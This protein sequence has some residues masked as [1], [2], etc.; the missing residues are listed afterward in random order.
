[1]NKYFIASLLTLS[2][3]AS[4]Q[5]TPPTPPGP[6]TGHPA[7]P[8]ACTTSG[9][10]LFEEKLELE[11]RPQENIVNEKTWQVTVYAGGT[12][13]RREVDATGKHRTLT[14]GCLSDDQLSTIKTALASATWTVKQADVTCAA[15]S[16]VF[17]SY[18]SQGKP[19]WAEHMC[20]GAYL[21]DTSANAIQTISSLLDRVTVPHDPPCCKK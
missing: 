5:P 9:G 1:M 13:Q 16:N 14:E 15:I 12:W 20:Q 19:L 7:F 17:T 6:P 4:A 8:K 10:V 21:D 18:S 3:I 11:Q 2:A